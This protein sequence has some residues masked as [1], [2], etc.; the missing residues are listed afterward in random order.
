MLFQEDPGKPW[1]RHDFLLVEALQIME[2]ERCGQCG[3]PIWMCHDETGAAQF[4]IDE[5]HCVVKRDIDLRYERDS[6][7]DIK[8]HGVAFLPRPFFV[9]GK[10]WVEV[11]DSYYTRQQELAK[12][13]REAEGQA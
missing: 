6:K 8:T 7:K 5:D 3:L 2:Q 10:S 11:R 13:L 9:D 12:E 1:R 4:S